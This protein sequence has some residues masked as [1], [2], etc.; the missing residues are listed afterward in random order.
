MMHPMSRPKTLASGESSRRK[1]RHRSGGTIAWTAAAMLSAALAGCVS[2]PTNRPS[3]PPLPPSRPSLPR[4][5]RSPHRL[6]QPPR[7]FRRPMTP[8]EHHTTRDHAARHASGAG[9]ILPADPAIL[10]DEMVEAAIKKGGTWLNKQFDKDQH[11]AGVKELLKEG[12]DSHAGGLDALAVYALI[13]AGLA[14]D[15]AEL[16]KQLSL[17]GPDMQAKIAAMMKLISTR[18][19]RALTPMV[20][21]PALWRPSSITRRSSMSMPRPA[22]RLR[23]SKGK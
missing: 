9:R 10:T 16:S 14:V 22:P 20:F 21:A 1:V 4:E 7:R 13:N 19:V 2:P 23:L 12:N 11:V 6:N 18:E 5:H 15:D 17:K 3:S 8:R